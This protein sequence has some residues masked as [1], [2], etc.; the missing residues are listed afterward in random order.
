MAP[1]S[2]A[3]EGIIPF[4]VGG[5]VFQTKYWVFGSLE[6]RTQAPLVV[7]HGG[8]GL[9]HDYLLP[10]SDLATSRP[11]IFY[12]Q[13]GNGKSA[14]LPNKEKQFWTIDLFIDELENLLN[15]FR[16][17]DG[18]HLIGHSWGGMLELEFEI[19]RKPKGLQSLIVTN[20][21][22]AME[23]WNRSNA[24][25]VKTFP[26]WVQEGMAIGMKDLKASAP[27]MRE[28]RTKHG[29]RIQPFPEEY[30]HTLD[31]L[32]S[33]SGDPTVAFAMFSS[34]LKDWNIIDSLH[35]VRVPVF[36]INGRFDVSQ[37]FVNIPM[38][39]SLPK[40]RW[41][42]FENSSHTPFWEERGKYMDTISKFLDT[43]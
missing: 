3:E 9:T 29:C 39:N 26:K 19:R 27:A 4:N 40:V 2:P 35:M 20:S 42:T 6:N 38:F 15:H 14:H 22:A 8:P 24:E 41:V 30:V 10:I 34:V 12:D 7:L 1:W 36:L 13:L 33:E 28:F 23:M 43:V 31:Q 5:E 17:S 25:L 18:F 16:I 11:V 21:L 32:F 37:D